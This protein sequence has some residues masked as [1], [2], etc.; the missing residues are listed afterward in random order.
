MERP[1][2]ILITADDMNYDAVGA[3]GCPVEGT[4]PNIDQLAKDGMIVDNAHVTIAVCQP[5]RSAI[6]TGLY[7]HNSQGEGFYSLRKEGV[8]I[9]PDLLRKGGYTV[10][11]LG[12]VG[13]STPYDEFK[14][15]HDIDM[16]ELGMGRN[17][18]I[19]ESGSKTLFEMADNNQNPFFLMMN[20]HDPHRPFHGSL[21]E[22]N[23][24][25]EEQRQSYPPPKRVFKAEEITIPGCLPELPEI[26]EEIA[27]YYSSIH[28]ADEIVGRVMNLLEKMG[29]RENTLVMFL[30]DN[31]MAFPFAKT[32]CYLNSTKTPFLA[33][34]PAQIKAGSRIKEKMVNGIDL[35]PTILEA[36]AVKSQT[37]MDGQSFLELL[38]GN[39]ESGRE[40]VYTQFFQ[41]AGRLNYPMRCIQNHEWG[42]IW[43]PWSN[44]EREFNNE[45][46][47]GLTFNSMKCEEDPTIK[48]RTE[49][50]LKRVPEELYNFKEDPNA[51]NNLIHEDEFEAKADE[52]RALLLKHLEDTQ[53]PAL[54][55]FKNRHDREICENLIE[56]MGQTL[57][58]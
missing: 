26:R 54:E 16:I 9:M 38:K 32:N 17:P 48:S 39:E 8:P 57:K 29:H 14:W 55:T 10:G 52:M 45:S 20:L 56:E 1:N 50:F 40:Y 15:D 47:S 35:M 13:H 11:I 22:Q 23:H 58:R 4:T 19:Y 24:F 34:W 51:L 21:Q 28:R 3:F 49:L 46:M 25:T 41:T 5:S 53:D 7:P 18:D 2:I 30:S 43:N 37:D 42:Y 31:G 6:M 12:K 36:C 33:R 27:Q 44:G